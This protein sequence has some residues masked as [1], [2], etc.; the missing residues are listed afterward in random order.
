MGGEVWSD[1]R[2]YIE[3]LD[4]ASSTEAGFN[5]LD[6]FLLQTD[7]MPLQQ[8]NENFFFDFSS[9]GLVGCFKDLLELG[10]EGVCFLDP[11]HVIELILDSNSH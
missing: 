9:A 8:S 2:K 10:L 7:S 11:R 3:I 1:S 6:I 4:L 5:A